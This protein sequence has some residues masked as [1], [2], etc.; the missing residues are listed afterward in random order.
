M[1]IS[2]QPDEDDIYNEIDLED[3]RGP[4]VDNTIRLDVQDGEEDTNGDTEN[5]A[6]RGIVT[7]QSIEVCLKLPIVL[8]KADSQGIDGNDQIPPPKH[9]I[10]PYRLYECLCSQSHR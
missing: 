5:A 4:A 6:A 8:W 10:T 1:S 7:G 3:L 9:T 2:I